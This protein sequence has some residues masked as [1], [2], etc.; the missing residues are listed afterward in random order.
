VY[1]VILIAPLLPPHVG[2]VVVAEGT[3]RATRMRGYVYYIGLCNTT[4]SIRY[5]KWLYA[6]GGGQTVGLSVFELVIPVVGLP[7]L[8][9]TGIR[10]L[11]VVKCNAP[12]GSNDISRAKARLWH[13]C[14][15]SKLR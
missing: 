7:A 10:N 6:V 14:K 13:N 5:R 12:T 8:K 9:L 2:C 1:V 15:E 4:G 3:K 11:G